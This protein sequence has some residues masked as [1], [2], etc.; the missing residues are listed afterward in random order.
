M[1]C[2][3]TCNP[4]IDYLVFVPEL[5]AGSINR[6]VRERI[7]YG[8]KGVNVS[9]VLQELGFPSVATGFLAG[10]TGS[11]LEHSLQGG[12]IRTDFVHLANG[13]TR[14]NVKI[15]SRGETDVNG[16]GPEITEAD[17]DALFGKLEGLGEGDTLVLAGSI[18]DT[19]PSDLYE[20]I[21]ERLQGRGVRFVVDATKDLL[22]KALPYRP[23]LVKPNN[24]ELG[25]LFGVRVETVDDTAVYA[26]RLQE[27]GAVNVLVSMGGKGAV[28]LD[29]TGRLH[30]AGAKQGKVV[31]TVG[32]GDSMVAGFLA[33][34][35]EK[36]DYAYA[37]ALGSAAGGATAFSEGLAKREDV[38]RLLLQP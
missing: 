15:R 32:A 3:V 31:N 1:I 14:I 9:L 30:T 17:V 38:E 22:R 2:T 21:L 37:L 33:G 27:L 28:L 35:E 7:F 16:R 23:F 6:A 36:R 12:R 26:K 20:R 4:A 8:G 34:Y 29:E 19:L 5:Q 11:A 24:D 13:F 25:E 10:F 18:P